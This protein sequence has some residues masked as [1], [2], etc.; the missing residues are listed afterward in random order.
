[1]TFAPGSHLGPYEVVSPL[2]AGGMGEVYRARDAKLGRDVAIK[3]L[4][5]A[6]ARDP[7]AL[8]RFE[9]DAAVDGAGRSQR[10]SPAGG[11]LPCWSRDGKELF[12]VS[13]DNDLMTAPVSLGPDLR[14]SAPKP[15]FSLPPFSYRSDYD[16]SR[17]GR[18]FLINLGAERARQPPL[19]VVLGW[20]QRLGGK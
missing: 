13:A 8:A 19:T 17:D 6:F 12:F 4:P 20:Q 1:M 9:R 14:F 15:L 18:R 7:D 10:V 16:V 11:S 2:G 3:V 5:E